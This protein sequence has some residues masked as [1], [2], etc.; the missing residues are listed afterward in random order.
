MNA[1]EQMAGRGN[2]AQG[3]QIAH[4]I[5]FSDLKFK[6]ATLEK[7]LISNNGSSFTDKAQLVKAIYEKFDGLTAANKKVI[8]ELV[9]KGDWLK[10]DDKEFKIKLKNAIYS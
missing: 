7:L 5:G 4:V 3:K 8:I 6:T 9:A 1:A 2:R 10:N